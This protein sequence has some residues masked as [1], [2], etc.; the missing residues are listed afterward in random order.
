MFQLSAIKN[1][2]TCKNAQWLHCYKIFPSNQI[3]EW[4]S[5]V[6]RNKWVELPNIPFLDKDLGVTKEFAVKC[7]ANAKR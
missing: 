4:A 5:L 3:F 7:D 2:R 6:L 1:I